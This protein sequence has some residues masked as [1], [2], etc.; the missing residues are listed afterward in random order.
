MTFGPSSTDKGKG[1]DTERRAC[2]L[3]AKTER[4]VES[5]LEHWPGC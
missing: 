5:D 2:R 3:E 4:S 1:H